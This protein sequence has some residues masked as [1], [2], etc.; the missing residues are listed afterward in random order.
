MANKYFED[1]AYTTKEAQKEK[2]R[3]LNHI[4][5]DIEHYYPENAVHLQAGNLLVDGSTINGV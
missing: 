5:K 4:K 2:A 3:Y 1:K